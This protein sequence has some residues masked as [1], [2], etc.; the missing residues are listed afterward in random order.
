MK[1][2]QEAHEAILEGKVEVNL[3]ET[4]QGNGIWLGA[5]VEI[6]PT[7]R[8]EGPALI[9]DFSRIGPH[10]EI[11]AYT[12]L[13]NNVQVKD[14]ASIKKSIL[15]NGCYIGE[16][17][18]LRGTV[19]CQQV[20]VE[21]G[22]AVYEGSAIGD[23]SK[24]GRRSTIKPE[25]KI[26]PQK[27]VGQGVIQHNSLVW[28]S[29]NR[30]NLFGN[31]GIPGPVNYEITPE[32]AA[33][34]GAA[35]GSALP[36][37]E[38]VA[39]S[40]DGRNPV[41]MLKN[42]FVSGL[43]SSGIHVRDLG[44]LPVPAHRYAVQVLQM[45][46]GVHLKS[47]DEDLSKIWIQFVDKKGHVL[48]P[49]WER[50]IENL[51]AREDFRRAGIEEIGR[52]FP[53]P[54]FAEI[55]RDHILKQ[56]HSGLIRQKKYRL[57]LSDHSPIMWGILPALWEELGIKIVPFAQWEEGKLLTKTQVFK[58]LS[59]LAQEVVNQQAAL[60]AILDPHGEKLYLVDDRGQIIDEDL[61]LLLMVSIIF[62]ANPGSR[63]A[64]PITAP[65]AVE[66]L[67]KRYGGQVIRTKTKPSAIMEVVADEEFSSGQGRYPQ[68]ALQFDALQALLK[69]LEFLAEHNL[70]LSRL[71]LSIPRV[72]VNME[73]MECPWEAKGKVMRQLIE[74]HL[75]E[76]VELLDGIKIYKDQGWALVLP[77]ADE[78]YYRIYSEGFSQE[79][80]E[81]L[82]S[83]YAGRIKSIIAGKTE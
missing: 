34:I 47:D 82:T 4:D 46:A 24:I 75:S 49:N 83:F 79:M 53:V 23:R 39:V 8:L 36:L 10:V 40:H 64:V 35:F 59:D 81:E 9:G 22:A 18:Q 28:G 7:A 66:I 5:G 2:Y 60:G 71:L 45:E 42:A 80:A 58:I 15:W 44:T 30:K 56:V 21:T 1:Q 11:K 13:G 73:M 41:Q 50:K 61:Y 63:V 70:S 37:G 3:A 51:Y 27:E 76:R 77:D 19:L 38:K 17:A 32:I 69:I 16:K 6:H 29:K 57:V 26:W 33:K 78:P 74:E 14:Y 65:Q 62:Q 67:A 52:L 68:A 48:N 12:V 43:L 72:Y 31:W 54:H 20:R 55:Y 25:V